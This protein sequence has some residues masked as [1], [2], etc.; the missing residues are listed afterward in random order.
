MGGQFFQRTA[1]G[2]RALLLAALFALPAG[3][4]PAGGAG[5]SV[6]RS[7]NWSGPGNDPKFLGLERELIRG[8]ESGH[9][10]VRVQVEQIPGPGLYEA[11]LLLMVL[12]GEPPDVLQLD[13][14]S[15]AVLVDNGLLLDLAPYMAADPDF[16]RDHYFDNVMEIARRGDKLFAVPL[17]F[18]PMVIVYNQRLFDAAGVP[19]PH[20]NWSWDDFLRAARALTIEPS[21]SRPK[22]YGFQ[23]E[24]WMPLWMP[25]IWANGGDVVGPDGRSVQGCFDGP[26]SMEAIRF[27]ADL[28]LVHRVA[29]TP[30]ES[31]AAGTD[32]FRAGRAAMILTGHWMLIEY[33]VDRLDI[34]VAPIPTNT[35]E[36]VTVMYASSLAV[37]AGARHPRLAWEYVKFMTS[38]AVQR[39]RVSTGLAISG[40]R[41]TAEH[42]AAH[43]GLEA[44]FL[45][46]AAYARPPI[47]SRVERYVACEDFGRE[48][49]E[50]ILNAGVPVEEAVQRA[51]RL[52]Q[53][54]L[55]RRAED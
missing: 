43:D 9:P 2:G 47:G 32:L 10:G 18:T 11:K 33:K 21:A 46:H 24:N 41:R 28:M 19:Y 45:R 1:S 35:G 30:R 22:Q 16:R 42:Y 17:D 53:K 36:P 52:M 7:A 50:D 26:R 37:A 15:A 8:F 25:W 13:A 12:S 29:P 38:E 48:M 34:G 54:V 51:A 49:F 31:A 39:R 40:N 20:D 3:C 6:L 4:G 5:E 23:F 14:S 27:L 44:E 55:A